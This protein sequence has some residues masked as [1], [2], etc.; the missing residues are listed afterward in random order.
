MKT[1]RHCL[2]AAVA[3]L[4]LVPALHAQLTWSVFNETTTVAGPASTATSGTVITVAAGQRVTLVANNFVPIDLTAAGT[5]SIT[6]VNFK[7]SGGL[8]T[9]G[10]G[11]RAVGYGLFN[12]NGTATNYADDSGYFTWLNGRA[13]GALI[14][15]KRRYGD[16]TQPSLMNAPANNTTVVAAS[17][18]RTP[19]VPGALSDGNFDSIQFHLQGRSGSVSF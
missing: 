2:G 15:Q 3:A 19:L 10:S 4:C 17:T 14:E 18:G 16:G 1:L 7:V 8:T 9:I 11:T 6:A 12:N 13:T 5:E